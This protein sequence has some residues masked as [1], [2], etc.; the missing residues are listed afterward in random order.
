MHTSGVIDALKKFN[1]YQFLNYYPNDE[2]FISGL[3]RVYENI[4]KYSLTNE[5]SLI[6]RQ[7]IFNFES[8]LVPLSQWVTNLRTGT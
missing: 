3:F 7:E 5:Q 1:Q 6:C 2:K 4:S 8:E